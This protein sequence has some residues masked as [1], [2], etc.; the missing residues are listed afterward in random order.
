[1]T[2]KSAILSLSKNI[3]RD[4]D[5]VVLGLTAVGGE[6][7]LVGAT[8]DVEKSYQKAYSTPL[9]AM[10]LT[11]GASTELESTVVLPRA[12]ARVLVVGLGDADV[13]AEQLRRA[14]GAALRTATQIPDADGLKVAVSLELSGPELIRAAGDAANPTNRGVE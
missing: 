8:G 14:V 7:T 5:I 10:A 12:G 1:M 6:P 2:R 3:E 4:A 11:L 9:L 13:T